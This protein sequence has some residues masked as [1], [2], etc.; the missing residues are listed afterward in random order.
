MTLQDQSC[1]DEGSALLMYSKDMLFALLFSDDA[2][3]T[4]LDRKQRELLTLTVPRDK[5][6]AIDF[7]KAMT[8]LSAFGNAGSRE[9]VE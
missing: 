6:E 8:E 3:N 7:M 9:C 5:V 2:C 1:T 4:H